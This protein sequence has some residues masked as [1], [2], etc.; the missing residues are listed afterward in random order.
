MRIN[1]KGFGAVEL[2]V[3]VVIVGALAG[4]GYMVYK[5]SA[6]KKSAGGTTQQDA[7]KVD[8]K[9]IAVDFIAAFKANDKSKTDSLVSAEGKALAKTQ[10]GTE[11]FYDFCKADPICAEETASIDIADITP[12]T[13]EYTSAGGV[14]G[15]N[16]KFKKTIVTDGSESSTTYVFNMVPF[17]SSWLVDDFNIEYAAQSNID[18]QL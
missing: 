3:I 14:K 4:G 16:L 11:S 15:K 6:D 1:Q 5:K 9:S 17:G 2:V 12:V 13:A 8:P 18:T 10:L 7:E